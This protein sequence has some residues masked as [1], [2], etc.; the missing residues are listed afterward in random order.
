MLVLSRKLGESIVMSDNQNNEVWIKVVR[1]SGGRVQIAFNAPIDIAIR[2]SELCKRPATGRLPN[3]QS[4][5]L[6]IFVSKPRSLEQSSS[7]R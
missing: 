4:M 2:R 6:R 7:L 5:S 1:I 3:C